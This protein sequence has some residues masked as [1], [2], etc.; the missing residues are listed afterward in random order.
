MRF[1]VAL[2]AGG[3]ARRM[4]GAKAQRQLGD[5]TLLEHAIRRT[6]PWNAPMVLVLRSS[7][8]VRSPGLRVIRDDPAIPGPLGGLAAALADAEDAGLEAVLTVPCDMP[9]LPADLPDRLLPALQ[10]GVSVAVA[11]SAGR[12]HPITAL[13]RPEVA[14]TLR[15][16]AGR[17][18]LSL[19]GLADQAGSVAVSWSTEDGDPF[20]NIN[21]PEDLDQA[22]RWN[23]TRASD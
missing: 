23:R 12:R 8:D 17:D 1:G 10:T 9:F 13:W 14:A 20:F 5:L 22:A 4:G 11:Q 2:L 15:D 18:Q 19:R 6:K 21:T 7:S 3:Q 16:R